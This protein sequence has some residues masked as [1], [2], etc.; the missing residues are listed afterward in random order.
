MLAAT[1]LLFPLMWT[2]LRIRRLEGAVL[3]AGFVAYLALLIRG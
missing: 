2:G 1:V 3:F